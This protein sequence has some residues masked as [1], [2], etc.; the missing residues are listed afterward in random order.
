MNYDA[1]DLPFFLAVMA[2]GLGLSLMTYRMFATRYEWPMGEWHINRPALPI[3]IGL[4]CVIIAGLFALARFSMGYVESGWGILI[5]GAIVAFVWTAFLRV[6]SQISL[7]LAP[8][9][10]ALMT[11]AWLVGPQAL[12]YRTVRS[13]I[14]ELRDQLRDQGVVRDQGG[15]GSLRANPMQPLQPGQPTLQPRARDLDQ[16]PG[17]KR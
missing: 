13:E 11:I 2:M 5:G 3:L 14:R 6:A 9:M 7:F 12:E 16:Q 15:A 4:I 17:V 1:F 8:G 10:T